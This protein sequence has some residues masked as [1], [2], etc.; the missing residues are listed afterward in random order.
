MVW[1]DFVKHLLVPL[2]LYLNLLGMVFTEKE[3]FKLD[4]DEV[5]DYPHEAT[6]ISKEIGGPVQVVWTRE[7]DMTQGPHRPGMSSSSRARAFHRSMGMG[8]A[9][10]WCGSWSRRR[11]SCRLGSGTCWKSSG[12]CL[13]KRSTR[14][15][16]VFWR[17]CGRCWGEGLWP[18]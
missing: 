7:D 12:N 2:S 8:E 6:L 18:R 4:L 13:V 9:I 5:L 11:A 3:T 16:R 17:R 1:L 10:N 15:R 14:S